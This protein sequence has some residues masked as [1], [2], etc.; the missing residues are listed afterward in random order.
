MSGQFLI[1]QTIKSYEYI[2][3]E[4]NHDPQTIKQSN[5]QSI[6]CNSSINHVVDHSTTPLS[7]RSGSRAVNGHELIVSLPELSGKHFLLLCD[8]FEQAE[9]AISQSNAQS[10]TFLSVIDAHEYISRSINLSASDDARLYT[11]LISINQQI[12]Q[13]NNQPNTQSKKGWWQTLYTILGQSI[14]RL[15]NESC[16]DSINHRITIDQIARRIES[17]ITELQHVIKQSTK[18]LIDEAEVKQCDDYH[19]D[20]QTINQSDQ[21]TVSSINQINRLLTTK[22]MFKHSNLIIT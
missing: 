12:N 10:V 13:S 11:A 22:M 19:S 18:R 5:K 14:D 16:D 7:N 8:I 2:R 21:H 20:D 3:R 15:N 17:H 1:D 4:R 6:H 9:L